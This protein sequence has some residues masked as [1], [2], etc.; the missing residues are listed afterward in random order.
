MVNENPTLKSL[1]QKQ[2]IQNLYTW[3][4]LTELCLNLRLANLK[5]HCDEREAE[6]LLFREI[7]ASK[8]RAWNSRNS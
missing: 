4:E 5:S 3:A 6:K 2:A 7:V 1:D 8:S